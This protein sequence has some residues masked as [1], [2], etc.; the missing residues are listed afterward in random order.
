MG[1]TYIDGTR[2]YGYDNGNRKTYYG[3]S[4]LAKEENYYYDNLHGIVKS[5]LC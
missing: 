3:N 2:I 4:K 5:L 1:A